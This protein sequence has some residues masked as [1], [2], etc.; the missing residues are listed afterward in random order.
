MVQARHS[1]SA[2]TSFFPIYFCHF[3][4]I[5]QTWDKMSRTYLRDLKSKSMD[6]IESTSF[7]ERGIKNRDIFY[8]SQAKKRYLLAWSTCKYRNRNRSLR[9]G[10]QKFGSQKLTQL[11]SYTNIG[12]GFMLTFSMRCN[13]GVVLTELTK[14]NNVTVRGN[15]VKRDGS[16]LVGPHAT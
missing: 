4:Y 13:L 5:R 2:F 9:F 6:I 11:F 7:Y 3:M 14:L 1:G 12:I 16:D 10:S 8:W 15:G